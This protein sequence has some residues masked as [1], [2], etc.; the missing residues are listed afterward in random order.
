[1][2]PTEAIARRVAREQEQAAR[3]KADAELLDGVQFGSAETSP[4]LEENDEPGDF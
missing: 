2:T 1:V 4:M 3:A